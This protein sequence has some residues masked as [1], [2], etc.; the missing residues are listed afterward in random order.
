MHTIL[1]APSF[2]VPGVRPPPL[3]SALYRPHSCGLVYCCS[4]LRGACA[5]RY[6]Y[7]APQYAGLLSCRSACRGERSPLRPQG[8]LHRGRSPFFTTSAR[9][10]C[11]TSETSLP[12]KTSR[13]SGLALSPCNGRHTTSEGCQPLV[14]N[15]FDIQARILAG[16]IMPRTLFAAAHGDMGMRNNLS[17]PS[18][19]VPGVRPPPLHSA[20]YRPQFCG[21]V[22]CCSTLR[23][24]RAPRYCYAAPPSGGA[25]VL[26]QRM[27]RG[28]LPVTPAGRSSSWAQP[29]LHYERK[30]GLHNE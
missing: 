29:I 13:V 10:V 20:L 4:T 16:G 19:C 22:Y 9:A 1:S 30:S 2:C 28:T 18:F 12:P 11:I 7:A 17:A 21:L 24:A 14:F 3:H 26:P 6:C 23:G 27:P 5:P 8:V 15:A 25:L